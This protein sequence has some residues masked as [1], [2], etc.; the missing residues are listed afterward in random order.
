MDVYYPVTSA[1]AAERGVQ[2]LSAAVAGQAERRLRR[3]GVTAD[4]LGQ[5]RY[6]RK[7]LPCSTQRLAPPASAQPYSM[8]AQKGTPRWDRAAMV[9]LR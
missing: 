3:A 1:R 2:K 7:C 5:V 9:L 4:A 8:H 6:L